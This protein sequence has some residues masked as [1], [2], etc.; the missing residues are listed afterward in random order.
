MVLSVYRSVLFC[1]TWVETSAGEFSVEDEI[2]TRINSWPSRKLLMSAL[3]LPQL[4]ATT[5][6]AQTSQ[7]PQPASTC[8]H[9]IGAAL[10]RHRGRSRP[11]RTCLVDHNE[12]R[13]LGRVDV[14]Q[15]Q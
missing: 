10:R 12:L 2:Y 4:T 14:R 3:K 15:Y 11:Y 6:E 13:S 5:G 1:T 8:A 7:P 9:T